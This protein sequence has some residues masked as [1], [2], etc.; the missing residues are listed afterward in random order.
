LVDLL[1]RQIDGKLIQDI[2]NGTT[3]FIDFKK[4]RMGIDPI[5]G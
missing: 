2:S 1:T 4:Q 5:S 3:V